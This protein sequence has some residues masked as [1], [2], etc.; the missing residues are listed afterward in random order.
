MHQI[1]SALLSGI[2]TSITD[3]ILRSMPEIRITGDMLSLAGHAVKLNPQETAARDALERLYRGA[4]FQPP[5]LAQ[6]LASVGV[7]AES[8]RAQLEALVKAK[9]LVKV[10][11]E[12][13]FHAEVVDHVKRSLAAHKG[14]R[15]TVPEFKEW[16]GVSRKHAIP[17]L[18]F[19][20]RERVT[21]REG[22]TRVVL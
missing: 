2:E 9:K 5:S 8:A 18:E 21:R 20:D 7:Q 13:I 16:T 10:S 17:L 1:R 3:E 15:F 14:K 4:G 6:A 11:A 22:D 19:L 12:F